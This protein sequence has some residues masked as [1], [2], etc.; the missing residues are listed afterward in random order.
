MKFYEK[1]VLAKMSMVQS[2]TLATNPWG[3]FAEDLDELGGSIT[4]YDYGS[5]VQLGGV[6]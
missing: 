3:S 5:G 6:Q 1:P 2:E 4:S